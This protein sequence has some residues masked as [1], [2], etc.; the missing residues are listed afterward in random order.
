MQQ[1]SL[2]F[3]LLFQVNLLIRKKEILQCL[4][5]LEWFEVACHRNQHIPKVFFSLLN[6]IGL[7]KPR[8][9]GLNDCLF[10]SIEYL[11]HSFNRVM[12]ERMHDTISNDPNVDP[13][14]LWRLKD[15]STKTSGLAG[16]PV[17]NDR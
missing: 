3:S 14:I 11:E 5:S 15:D 8:P 10:I 7:Q 4:L 16:L 6:S 9:A 13:Y 2:A 1:Y 12:L 17:R